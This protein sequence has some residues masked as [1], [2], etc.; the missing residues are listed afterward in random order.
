LIF[1]KYAN[2]GTNT[3]EVHVASAASNYQKRIWESG[4]T[5]AEEQDGHWT[6]ADWDLDGRPDLVFIKT[7]NCGTNTVEVHVAS[8]ASGYKTRVWES[9][10]TFAQE[11]NGVWKLIDWDGDRKPDL[12][13]IKTSN[14]GTNTVEVHVASA[15]SG[16]KTRIWE[17]GSTFAEEQDGTWTLADYDGDAK[18]DLVFL[19][20]SNCGTN[21]VE[22]HVAS[23]ASGYKTRVWE[24]GSTFAQEDNGSWRFADY[25]GDGHQDLC[26]VK[27]NNTPSH[28]VEFHVASGT[29]QYQSRIFE[30]A[31]TFASEGIADQ[32]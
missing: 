12:V 32:D 14:C 16:F 17:S 31:T 11:N 24:S 18:P 9:G 2:C 21:S 4:S 5:F 15:A 13:Y 27:I 3:V 19:K 28:F 20:T 23:A 29:S 25:N 22:V 8:A 6:L 30:S 26:Y 7:S 10:S 1:I